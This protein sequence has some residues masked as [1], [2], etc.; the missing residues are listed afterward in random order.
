MRRHISSYRADGLCHAPQ[1]A[2]GIRAGAWARKGDFLDGGTRKVEKGS[3]KGAVERGKMD[4]EMEDGV[5]RR[6]WGERSDFVL[7]RVVG[8][9]HQPAPQSRDLLFSHETST[10]DQDLIIL[11]RNR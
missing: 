11:Q 7:V 2:R 1:S 10:I 5:A 8:S 3:E 9:L 6:Q 4:G